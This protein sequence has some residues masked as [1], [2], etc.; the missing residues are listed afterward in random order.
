MM[1]SYM[2]FPKKCDRDKVDHTTSKSADNVVD[3]ACLQRSQT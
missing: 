1:L 3:V 2:L